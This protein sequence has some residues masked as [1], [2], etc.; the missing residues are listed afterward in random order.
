MALP[1][2]RELSPASAL[3]VNTIAPGHVLDAACSPAG[4]RKRRISLERTKC[5]F[6]SRLGQPAGINA[7]LVERIETNPMLNGEVIRL[8]G[9]IR[10][11]AALT[12]QGGTA[13]RTE[14][15]RG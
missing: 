5:P 7:K 1:I 12:L 9:A 10:H 13:G 3:R 2:A 14:K 6:P 8:D 11:G 4:R 15:G